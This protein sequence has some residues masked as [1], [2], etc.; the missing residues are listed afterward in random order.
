MVSRWCKIKNNIKA[1]KDSLRC[2][3]AGIVL[4]IVFYILTKIFKRSLCPIK[5]F[6]GFS[7]FGCGMT[8]AFLSV[9]KC[10][11]GAA[12]GYNVL[13]ILLFLGI[14]IYL[15]IYIFDI[16][17]SKNGIEKLE[18]FLSKKYM[19]FI[20]IFILLIGYYFNNIK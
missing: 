15:L 8:R 10:E 4:F 2:I 16:V 3:G 11:F 18:K 19:Y 6:L 1:K 14:V 12:I 17:F 5:N 13:S 7:C 9:L 20:Y